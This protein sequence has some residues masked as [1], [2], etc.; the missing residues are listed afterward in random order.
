MKRPRRPHL[1][2]SLHQAHAASALHAPPLRP[3]RAAPPLPLAAPHRG[4]CSGALKP[5]CCSVR[6]VTTSSMTRPSE[7]MSEGGPQRAPSS[8]SGAE[9]SSVP[10]WAAHAGAAE[11]GWLGGW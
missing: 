10:P 11:V 8:C 1:Q 7:K 2:L 6:P 4:A 3:H 5:R 9:Y